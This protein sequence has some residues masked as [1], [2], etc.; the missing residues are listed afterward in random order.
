VYAVPT[1]Q[2]ELHVSAGR[3]NHTGRKE[4]GV[5]KM[6]GVKDKRVQKAFSKVGV[7]FIP[8]NVD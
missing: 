7:G 4:I 1:T 6:S 3:A 8:L 5:P 2:R